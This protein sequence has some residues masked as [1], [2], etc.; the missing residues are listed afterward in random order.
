M[1][2][3]ILTNKDTFKVILNCI[4]QKSNSEIHNIN[5]ILGKLIMLI[6]KIS[7]D[8]SSEKCVII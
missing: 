5:A 1:K 2:Y 7:I 4:L 3:E 8:L 6:S